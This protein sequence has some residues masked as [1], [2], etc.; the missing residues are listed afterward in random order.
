MDSVCEI[1]WA[2]SQEKVCLDHPPSPHVTWLSRLHSNDL[3]GAVVS[4]FDGSSRMGCQL[5]VSSLPLPSSLFPL[6][7]VP[8]P[9]LP[10]RPSSLSLSSLYSLFSLPSLP[11]SLSFLFPIPSSPFPLV[12][13]FPLL[14]SLSSLFP[15]SLPSSL[16][17]CHAI[18]IRPKTTVIPRQIEIKMHQISNWVCRMKSVLFFFV[19]SRTWILRNTYRKL[20]A[21]S[22][23]PCWFLLV[24]IPVCSLLCLH[25]KKYRDWKRRRTGNAR[26][27]QWGESGLIDWWKGRIGKNANAFKRLSN[28][29]KRFP[30]AFEFF[31]NPP[32]RQ[33]GHI[34][35]ATCSVCIL[36]RCT[37]DHNS[38]QQ[39]CERRRWGRPISGRR[40]K[41][42]GDNTRPCYRNREKRRN[43]GDSWRNWRGNNKRRSCS[44]YTPPRPCHTHP[45]HPCC[46]THSLTSPYPFCQVT[47]TSP[48][49]TPIRR[50]LSPPTP[51]DPGNVRLTSPP[52]VSA[53]RHSHAN[54]VKVDLKSH[55][56][57]KLC[58]PCA[59]FILR[60]TLNQ[61][62]SKYR[63]EVLSFFP[64]FWRAI[65]TA[66]GSVIL[67]RNRS[68]VIEVTAW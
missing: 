56:E 16:H 25:L 60:H 20:L 33:E 1:T 15:S 66:L 49:L 18:S 2:W 11:Y 46:P 6:P 67:C 32:F 54:S 35:R 55:L 28:A 21:A 62:I 47:S 10:S 50:P 59:Q 52:F 44:R 61:P 64:K 57:C 51:V 53:L 45:P 48:L 38:S 42:E 7:L 4:C 31:P 22:I 17:Q 36:S 34:W 65:K 27:V 41:S 58:F 23:S 5:Q 12:P 14:P 43:A 40:R 8:L 68:L 19:S 13:F 30:N 39:R 9:S 24:A 63:G 37:L 3:P 29:L 26:W